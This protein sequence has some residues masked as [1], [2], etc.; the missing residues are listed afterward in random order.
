MF[1]QRHQRLQQPVHF[2]LT[3]NVIGRRRFGLSPDSNREQLARKIEPEDILVGLVVT[4]INGCL[5][6]KSGP[7]AFQ[8]KTLVGGGREAAGRCRTSNASA[9][10][11]LMAK[12]AARPMIRS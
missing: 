12:P 10:T 5:A 4:D 2:A 6:R 3:A 9:T 1:A 8:G 11:R 7:L